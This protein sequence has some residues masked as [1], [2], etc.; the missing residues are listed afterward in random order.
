M[1]CISYIQVGSYIPIK[2]HVSICKYVICKFQAGTYR[3]LDYYSVFCWMIS[4][5]SITLCLVPAAWQ[6]LGK[7]SAQIGTHYILNYNITVH[8]YLPKNMHLNMLHI[9]KST[10]AHIPWH[11]ML[12]FQMFVNV[13]QWAYVSSRINPW[14]YPHSTE[15]STSNRIWRALVNLPQKKINPVEKY[16][17][18][19]PCCINL[20]MDDI[21]ETTAGKS[22]YLLG[23]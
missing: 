11:L 20:W 18:L 17:F 1:L 22:F 9:C 23:C 4:S 2:T 13:A 7:C 21:R 3:R 14:S 5:V 10:Y 16:L 6:L 15:E 12:F 8:L 19:S